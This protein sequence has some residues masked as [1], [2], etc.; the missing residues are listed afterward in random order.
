MASGGQIV[1]L[2]LV[3]IILGLVIYTGL[4]LS[5]KTFKKTIPY[6]N[7]KY[8]FKKLKKVALDVKAANGNENKIRKLCETVRKEMTDANKDSIGDHEYKGF[9]GFTKKKGSDAL[10]DYIEDEDAYL[11]LWNGCKFIT[12]ENDNS[13][14]NT[15]SNT[16]SSNTSSNT[17]SSNISNTASC[18]ITNGSNVFVGCGKV[19]QSFQDANVACSS[20]TTPV[21]FVWN[22]SIG[23]AC[24]ILEDQDVFKGCGF[25]FQRQEDLPSSNCAQV[26]E[27]LKFVP[28]QESSN[29][30]SNIASA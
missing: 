11:A 5:G 6:I 4:Y 29:I 18:S 14:S 26:E 16:L 22:T 25:V 27:T 21:P 12:S 17:L 13:S 10:K 15:S 9:M 20:N 1:A 3:L 23:N 7:K 19:F 2:V 24:G 30:S 8:N 28:T